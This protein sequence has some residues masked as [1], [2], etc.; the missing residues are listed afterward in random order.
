MF[1]SRNRVLFIDT[2]CNYIGIYFI[3]DQRVFVHTRHDKISLERR[4]KW[5]S[6]FHQVNWQ[7]FKIE[8]TRVFKTSSVKD[9]PQ[10]I[11]DE[12]LHL[13]RLNSVS[14]GCET[15]IVIGSLEILWGS[16]E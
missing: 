1:N 2:W 10:W 7:I 5:E 16:E 3:F 11:K 12:S 6:Q 13:H 14:L 9:N 8:S 4:I 15:F